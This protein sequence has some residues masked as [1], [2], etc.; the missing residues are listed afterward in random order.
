MVGE[1]QIFCVHEWKRCCG[2]AGQAR[3][4]RQQWDLEEVKGGG[5]TA[6]CAERGCD[7]KPWELRALDPSAA[8]LQGTWR[9]DLTWD[10]SIPLPGVSS[11]AMVVGD[12]AEPS[13]PAAPRC[14]S[15]GHGA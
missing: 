9:W 4:G 6:V 12:R 7:G 10:G 14:S 11:E 1:L 3:K 8:H 2:G 5:Q 15:A 13:S